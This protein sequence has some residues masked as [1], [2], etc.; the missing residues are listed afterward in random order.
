MLQDYFKS[1]QQAMIDLIAEMAQIESPSHDKTLV[2]R[3]GAFVEG[4]LQRLGADVIRLFRA[5]VGDILLAK[6]NA[7]APGKPILFLCHMDT[8]WA[9]GTLEHMPVY[10][11]DDGKLHGPGTI[12]MKA[13]IAVMLEAIRG[14]QAHE[15]FPN[16]PIW[17][18]LTTDEE[19]G[20]NHSEEAIRETAAKC[21]LVLVM[22]P[23]TPDGA[24]K[25]WRKGGAAYRFHI[26]GRAAHAG[27]APEQGINALI[28]LAQQA[29]RLN[30]MND[31]KNGTSVS[32]TL[33]EG[34]SAANVIPAQATL[35]VDTRFLTLKAM[36][37]VQ[38]AIE[39]E[40]IPF[41]PG[42]QVT[43]EPIH[44]RA[45]MENN[46]QMQATFDQ[47]KQLGAHHGITIRGEGSGGVSDGNFTSSLGIPTLD[48]LGPSGDGL[49]AA[50]EHVLVGTL[51]KRAALIA[52]I[53]CEWEM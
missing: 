47:L 38:R 29:M 7:D 21:G 36:E 4:R 20:S 16:R 15:Q 48:G 2:D 23:A 10:L 52:A 51:S 33:A 49:H 27:G 22:E 41:I 5:E 1:Q 44:S 12:D 17:A 28:E 3:M 37:Q 53:L 34:G 25:L 11:S 46:A 6:W 8:V 18:L 40:T 26:T 35:T 32:V 42:A 50:H 19:T 39:E 14:L 31:L 43:I 13:G 30:G 24:L 9:E 45:P